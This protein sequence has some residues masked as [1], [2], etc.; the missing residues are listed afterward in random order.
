MNQ[1]SYTLPPDIRFGILSLTV[2]DLHRALSFY[3]GVLGFEVSQRK[4]NTVRLALPGGP[5]LLELNENPKAQPRPGHTGLYHF[6]LLLPN[7]VELARAFQRLIDA[8]Y[9][10]EGFADHLVSEAIYLSDPDGNGI[11]LYRDR[12]REEWP[13]DN[14]QLSMSNAPLDINGLLEELRGKKHKTDSLHPETIIG[15][16]HLRVASIPAAQAFYT[17]TLGFDLMQYFGHSAAFVSAGGYHHHIGFNTWQSAGSPPPPPD[18][19]GLRCLT[20][21]LPSQAELDSLLTHLKETGADL[22][23]SAKELRI[24]DPS[25]NQIKLGVQNGV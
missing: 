4:V 13:F 9:N 17:K 3:Q 18:S 20:L 1:E 21:L 19:T 7:R 12:P 15:H 14:G 5:D 22:H 2:S 10:P 24:A 23:A 8:R 16:L 11:E 25:G 6:A